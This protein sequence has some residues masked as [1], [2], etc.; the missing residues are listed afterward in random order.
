MQHYNPL[1]DTTVAALFQVA[2]EWKLIAQMPFGR[3]TAPADEKSYAP[4]SSR[5]RIES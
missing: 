2:S 4:L 1:I 5:L 3:P